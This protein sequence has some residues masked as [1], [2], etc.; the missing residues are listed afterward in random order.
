MH[1]SAV[2]SLRQ[3]RRLQLFGP[4]LP[5]SSLESEIS[6]IIAE[7]CHFF[8]TQL[9]DNEILNIFHFFLAILLLTSNFSS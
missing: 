8:T 5:V 9:S 2:S 7:G 3:S 1:C 6:W 4:Y